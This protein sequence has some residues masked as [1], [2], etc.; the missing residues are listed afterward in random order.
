[1][2]P[3]IGLTTDGRDVHSTAGVDPSHV[4]YEA[5][6][7]A[8]LRAGGVPVLLAPV[9]P[10]MAGELLSRIDG[11]VLTGGGDIS[12]DVY[13]GRPHDT[14]YRIDDDRDGFELAAARLAA[15]MRLPTLAICRGMQM[16]NVAFGGTLIE[17]LPTELGVT[18]SCL[19]DL[20][21]ARHQHVDVTPGSRLAQA[22][23]A[24]EVKVNSIHHQGLRAVAPSLRVTARASDGVV[25]GVEHEDGAWPMWAVQ[26]HPEYLAVGDDTALALFAALVEAADA[27]RGR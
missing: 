26:W 3:V 24:T 5:Y 23:G 12:P 8:V 18:H 9:P 20:S 14:L 21:H 7:Q 27:G 19:G 1:M 22:V 13:G 11:L 25:E 2:P 6:T 17:D 4:L 16:L 10:E 15:E